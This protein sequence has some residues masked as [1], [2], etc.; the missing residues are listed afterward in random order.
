M[1]PFNWHTTTSPNNNETEDKKEN[2]SSYIVFLPYVHD[3]TK[4]EF[5]LNYHL[6][7]KC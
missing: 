4:I 6:V 1:E 3:T 2:K 5:I 7:L